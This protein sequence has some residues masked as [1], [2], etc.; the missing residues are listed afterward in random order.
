MKYFVLQ[1][2]CWE[3]N[4]SRAALSIQK[5]EFCIQFSLWLSIFLFSSELLFILYTIT[6]NDNVY[7]IENMLPQGKLCP[8]YEY[9]IINTKRTFV[10]HSSLSKEQRGAAIRAS[11]SWRLSV[12]WA[13][14]YFS[15]EIT[16]F[17]PLIHLRR[18]TAEY[19]IQSRVHIAEIN[20]LARRSY[21]NESHESR[22][23]VWI[24]YFVYHQ[25]NL[26]KTKANFLSVLFSSPYLLS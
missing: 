23:H 9:A 1:Y 25:N 10:S 15:Q 8:V 3:K 13:R 18:E 4:D 14:C 2:F 16:H 5:K 12:S 22:F 26:S 17:P 19:T 20:Q 21:L 11:S 7:S 24:L 6:S